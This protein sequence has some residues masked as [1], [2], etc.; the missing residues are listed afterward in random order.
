[1]PHNLV[2]R[3]QCCSKLR[4]TV[5]GE[6]YDR[7]IAHY[8][9]EVSNLFEERLDDNLIFN[10]DETH[11]ILDTDDGR[12]IGIL[13]DKS[14]NYVELC[15]R[16]EGFS[17]FPVVRARVHACIESVFVVI[18]HVNESHPILGVPDDMERVSYRSGKGSW[19]DRVYS[20]K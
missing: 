3:V 17:V 19:I 15:G 18:R 11:L 9:G 1:M 6:Y 2:I 8:L 20:T 13:G 10:L 16:S 5:W 7:C 14:V 4:N 12:S